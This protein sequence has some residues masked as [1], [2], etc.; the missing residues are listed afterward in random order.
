MYELLEKRQIEDLK[1]ISYLYKHKKSGARIFALLNDDENKVFSIGFRTPPYDDTGLPHILEH[2]VLCGSKNFP[3]KDPF[4]ELVKGSLNTFLNAMTYPDKTVYPVASCNDKDFRNLM[5][6][7]MDAVFYPNIYE[8][9]EI[10][11]QE[12]WSY[13]L[14][15]VEGEIH[16]NGVVYNE[17]KGAFSS[18]ESILERQILHSLFP[19]SC[20]SFE[21]GGDPDAIPTL[22]YSKFLEFHGKYYH[23]S[24]SYI[25]LYGDID[26][27][28]NLDWLDKN[29]LSDFDALEVDSEISIQ[30]GFDTMKEFVKEYP[31]SEGESESENT[32]L[33]Y[34]AVIG[35]N[36]DR[37]MYL[38]FQIIEYALLSM[39]GAPLKQ[40]LL[41]RGIGKDVYGS[42]DNGILQPFFTVTAKSTEPEKKDEFIN[43]IM[44]T[45]KEIV[46]TGIDRNSILAA[47]NTFEFKYREADFGS[48]PKG[49]V[50]GLQAYDS[51]LYDEK[52][53]LMHIEV[54]K[55]FEMLKEKIETGYYE[56][57]VEDYLIN[58]TH[59]SLITLIPKKGLNTKAENELKER[60][61]EYKKSLSEKE[62]ERLVEE[63][64]ALEEYKD[65]P[66]SKEDLEKIPLLKIDDIKKEAEPFHNKMRKVA[67]INLIH[68]DVFTNGIA[69]VEM[70]FRA[71]EIPEELY[72]YLGFIKNVLGYMDTK[73][74]TCNELSNEINMHTG[75]ISAGTSL[76][77]DINDNKN[78]TITADIRVKVLYSNIEKA[79]E[80]LEEIMFSTKLED[81]KRLYEIVAEMKSRLKMG[82]ESSGNSAAALRAMSYYSETALIRERINGIEFYK[83]VEKI[84]K[85]FENEKAGLIQGIRKLIET[86]FRKDNLLVS[87]TGDEDSFKRLCKP[88][89]KCSKNLHSIK[90]VYTTPEF[91]PEKKNEGFKTSAGIQYVARAGNFVDEG[92]RYQ[93]SLKVLK[94]ILNYDYLWNNVRV[95]GGAY[96]CG[97]TFTR[98]GDT[99]FVSYRDPNLS[100]TNDVFETMADY[101]KNFTVDERDMTKYIIGTVS[102]MD[103]P[104]TPMSK[105]NRSLSAYMSNVT[106]EQIQK[107]RDEVL[108]ANQESIRKLSGLV[109]SVIKQKNL[110]VIGN[111]NKIESEK[112]LFDNVMNLYD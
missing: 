80:L 20:Y 98:S 5:N 39:P 43:V 17:M 105:G 49:L 92:Y 91:K 61:V 16:Y 101:I 27:E 78:F 41:D 24:N 50:Y 79:F 11:K 90:E 38:A 25:Y 85:D 100:K 44:G 34:N 104:L 103:T 28:E 30:P 47:L 71:N 107:E 73:S 88:L 46:K 45:L 99:Y 9:E 69:Y 21:S 35:T 4:V 55:T 18:P 110:C 15:T 97:S 82:L 37:E 19:D 7:Y 42:Y 22:E 58:N 84:E 1:S 32:Y 23:P 95:K 31:V 68:H 10:F 56:K 81:E 62:L 112:E 6:V 70:L 48:I 14:D 75:G 94:V 106:F 59:S 33:S 26:L 76:Y 66:S 93:G 96:G 60:L 51:W 40:A 72:P 77:M 8:R 109:E 64:K 54:T 108:E 12:G 29:Y 89:E 86:V 63:T 3:A 74:Y 102:D 2:S 36:L 57:L 111:E 53:P 52:D 67:D 13:N 83:F 65:I 87:L